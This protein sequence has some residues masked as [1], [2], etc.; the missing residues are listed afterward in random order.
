MQSA[1]SVV[2]LS[3]EAHCCHVYSHKA[4]CAWPL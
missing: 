4:S 2:S 1:L 3:S